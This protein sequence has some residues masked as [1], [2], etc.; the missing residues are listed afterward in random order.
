VPQSVLK[1]PAF[2]SP[3]FLTDKALS[4]WL[5]HDANTR[6]KTTANTSFATSHDKR[7]YIKQAHQNNSLFQTDIVPT[8]RSGNIKLNTAS[9]YPGLKNQ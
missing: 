8:P 9:N 5:A 2:S 1:I 3:I 4:R 6:L 7:L